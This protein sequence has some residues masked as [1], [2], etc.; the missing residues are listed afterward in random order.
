MAFH[1]RVRRGASVGD[2]FALEPGSNT[3][4]RADSNTIVLDDDKVSVAHARIDVA[5]GACTLEDLESTNG[6][7]VNGTPTT[8]PTRLEPGDEVGVGNLLLVFDDGDLP[9]EPPTRK[10]RVVF[11]YGESRPLVPV[12]WASGETTELLPATA[13]DVQADRLRHLYDVLTALYRV[14]GLVSRA[15]TLD[16]LLGNILEVVFDIVPADHGS[17]L[18]IEGGNGPLEPL[19]ARC[20]HDAEHT[21]AISETICREVVANGRGIL[22]RDA[23]E[24]DRFRGGDSIQL[25]GIRSA[26]CV[27]IRTP[28]Q[29]FGVLYLDTRSPGSQFTER[30]LDLLSAIGSEVGL[31]VENFRLIQHALEAERLAAIGQ[32]VAGLSH[33]TKNVL[34]SIEAARVLIDAA[35][36]DDDKESLVEAWAA[37]NEN[38][39]LISELVLNMLSYS[40]RAEPSRDVCNP[41]TIASQLVELLAPRASQHGTTLELH[42]DQAVPTTVLDAGAL[43]RSLLNLL[44]NAIDASAPAAADH[45]LSPGAVTIS[46]LWDPDHRRI[47]LAVTDNGPGIAPHELPRIFEPFFTTKGSRGTGLGLA[48]TRK[49][50]EGLGGTINVQSTPGQGTTFTLSLPAASLQDGQVDRVT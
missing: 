25:F 38:T 8:T 48:V 1:L 46:S 6:T 13:H 33:Y 14:T 44:T 28:R 45:T 21:V 43:H 34:Q 31:A 37:L 29:L 20:R 12:A 18:S 26:M 11:E 30:D 5:D 16:E 32:A 42:L 35:I 24:D 50:I 7:R 36:A 27:P 47:G 22:T 15:T 4:G 40:R 23:S 39:E 49:I 19:A 17:V 3:I 2:V 9:D 41:N 10:V